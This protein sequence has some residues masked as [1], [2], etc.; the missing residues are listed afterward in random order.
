[1]YDLKY[2]LKYKMQKEFYVLN[3][4]E[5]AN[6]SCSSSVAHHFSCFWPQ[7]EHITVVYNRSGAVKQPAAWGREVF[8]QSDLLTMKF[9][10][11]N[12]KKRKNKTSKF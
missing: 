8:Q 7:S 3:T 11:M 10:F 5:G 2:M 1:M 6:V 4:S 12:K 9:F